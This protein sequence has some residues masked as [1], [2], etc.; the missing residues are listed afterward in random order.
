MTSCP[1]GLPR[2]ILEMADVT[3][4][5]CHHVISVPAIFEP[6]RII[7]LQ[8]VV[9]NDGIVQVLGHQY[10]EVIVLVLLVALPMPRPLVWFKT[11]SSDAKI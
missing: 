6:Q 4:K 9:V 5:R 7:D 3:L 8:Q 10:E 1:R 11:S 2:Q